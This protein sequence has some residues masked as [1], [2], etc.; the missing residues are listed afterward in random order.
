MQ[1][2]LRLLD[3]V[4]AYARVEVW[5]RDCAS[6]ACRVMNG[7]CESEDCLH[8]IRRREKGKGEPLLPDYTFRIE[9]TYR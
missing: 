6:H 5:S 4:F 8:L 2:V 1:S 3:R 9:E 7:S